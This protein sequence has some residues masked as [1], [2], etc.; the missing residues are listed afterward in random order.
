MVR[1]NTQDLHNL[2]LPSS[3]MGLEICLVK[4]WLAEE[5]KDLRRLALLPKNRTNH[6]VY[7]PTSHKVL[8]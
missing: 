5:L 8:D 2:N 6:K 1:N 4:S 3:D 7:P